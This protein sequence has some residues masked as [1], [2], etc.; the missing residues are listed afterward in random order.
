MRDHTDD[1][2]DTDDEN[3][4]KDA[5]RLF[6]DDMNDESSPELFGMYDYSVQGIDEVMDGSGVIDY[7][8]SSYN[9][10]DESV[11]SLGESMRDELL[12]KRFEDLVSSTKNDKDEEADQES[13]GT[14]KKQVP[15]TTPNKTKR[16]ERWPTTHRPDQPAQ[17]SSHLL[18]TQW[19]EFGDP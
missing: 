4:S 15:K 10:H 3:S 12:H 1:N 17:D 16:R 19:R 7:N 18:P 6:H 5:S 14:A 8:Q 11:C 13:E 9:R 2:N